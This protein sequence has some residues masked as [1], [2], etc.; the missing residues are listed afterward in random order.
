MSHVTCHV[1]H[2]MCH[3]SHFFLQRGAAYEW[4]VCYQ[5]VP[6]RL[7][8]S[9]F[10]HSK[11][12]YYLFYQNYQL[13]PFTQIIQETVVIAFVTFVCVVSVVLEIP[14][15]PVTWVIPP[16]VLKHPRYPLLT[17]VDTSEAS[18]SQIVMKE[19]PRKRPGKDFM[20]DFFLLG[21]PSKKKFLSF[22]QFS[23]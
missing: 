19:K 6:T 4:R 5:W 7:V 3:M 11:C 14:F 15:S 1:S 23:D 22:G 16:Q 10:P 13:F 2:V 9:C 12:L 20:S 18:P 8:F 21:M 17:P